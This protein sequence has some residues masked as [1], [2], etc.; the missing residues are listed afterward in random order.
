MCRALRVLCVARDAD[1]L[2]ALKRAATSATWELVGGATSMEEAV[3]QVASY[4]P[5]V[6]VLGEGVEGDAERLVRGARPSVRVVIVAAAVRGGEPD[7]VR[8]AIAG[9]PA[10]GGPVRR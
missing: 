7:A 3:S 5:D 8:L 1:E 10:P 2:Q 9:L 6:L 4:A